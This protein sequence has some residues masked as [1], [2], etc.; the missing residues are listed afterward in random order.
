MGLWARNT[1]PVMYLYKYHKS[2]NLLQIPIGLF[3]EVKG[4][5]DSNHLKY[6]IDLADMEKADISVKIPLYDYQEKAVEEMI[7]VGYGILQSKAGSGKTQMGIA[8]ACKLGYRTLWL[9]HTQDLLKQSYN[10]AKQYLSE[11]KL[12]TI[13]GG[14]VNLGEI[15]F[16]TVQTMCK[17]NL[18][19]YKYCFNTIIVDECHRVSG[20]PTRATQFSK[21]IESLAARHKFGLSATIHRAD[22]LEKCMFAQLGNVAYKVPDAVISGKVMTVSV[23]KVDTNIGYDDIDGCFDTDGTL[24]YS[25]FITALGENNRRNAIVAHIVLKSEDNRRILILS[26]RVK[27]LKNL[28]QLLTEA[29][30]LTGNTKARERDEIIQRAKNGEIKTI[31]ST[32]SLAKE[33][34]DIPCLT[35]L[36]M[37]T[38]VKDYAIVVQSVGRVARV[39]ENKPQPVVWDLVDDMAKCKKMYLQRVR[40]YRKSGCNIC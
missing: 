29:E 36:I 25:R 28:K 10:R 9:T 26:D 39:A 20:T 15:T 32:Y 3:N 33:G 11:D 7:K 16:A 38:P 8:L 30:I 31:L 22:K 14:K 17:L 5:L 13:T 4:L 27:H 1:P 6:L 37:A 23:K 24:V 12:G 34:L 35:D 19:D 40:H 18:H 2:K 21:V